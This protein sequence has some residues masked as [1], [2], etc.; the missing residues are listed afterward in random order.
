MLRDN[1]AGLIVRAV[2]NRTARESSDDRPQCLENPRPEGAES[3]LTENAPSPFQAEPRHRQL[4][5]ARAGETFR[6][7]SGERAIEYHL[8]ILLA[9]RIR[10]TS[11][12]LLKCIQTN[13]TR[14]KMPSP[15]IEIAVTGVQNR[16]ILS[17][18][19][20]R[21]LAAKN[22]AKN[23]TAKIQNKGEKRLSRKPAATA[24]KPVALELLIPQRA[25]TSPG[26]SKPTN[27]AATALRDL[28]TINSH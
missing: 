21:R 27:I 17:G 5:R 2:G 4:R 15:T 25:E 13:V 20:L 1:L 10:F 9:T 23:E 18:L 12:Y 26:P 8:F 14:E 16:R 7:S 11:G 6:S 19:L 22:K 28:A 24:A 3:T